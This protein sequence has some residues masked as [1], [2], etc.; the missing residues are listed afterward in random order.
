MFYHRYV[1][2]IILFH[3]CFQLAGQSID[4]S[5]RQAPAPLYRDPIYDGAAD[6]VLI[7][8]RKEKNWW[9]FYSARRANI[10]TYDLSAYFGTRIGAATST[11][12]GKTWIFKAYLDLE[13]ERA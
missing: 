10:P 2:I 12:N 4:A 11:D 9:M 7:W 6:P 13:F 3:I 5:I 8:N 1:A